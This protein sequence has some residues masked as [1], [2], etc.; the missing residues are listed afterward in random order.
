MKSDEIQKRI[1]SL[2]P[3]LAK[4]RAE[5]DALVEEF[6]VALPR[7]AQPWMQKTLDY[8]IA[9]QSIKVQS[10]NIE[11]V[12]AMKEEVRALFSRL[13]EVALEETKDQKDWPHNRAPEES[14][15]GQEKKE[16]FFDKAFRSVISH[17][18]SVL[19]RYGLLT[20]PKGYAQEW[21]RVGEGRFR[22]AFNPGFQDLRIPSVARYGE[23]FVEW[24]KIKEET[25][26]VLDELSKAKA[27]ELWDSA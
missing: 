20:L 25:E 6:R 24:K 8:A 26:K 10:F 12:R 19:D 7:F 13:P 4:K 21:T 5:L 22:Y 16:P 23:V 17:I 14:V 15:Y 9:Q 18:A 3:Q 27:K 11:K 2:E 1:S